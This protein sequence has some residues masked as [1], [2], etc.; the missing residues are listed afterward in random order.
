MKKIAFIL[1][2]TLAMATGVQAQW[3]ITT[4]IEGKVVN[5][6]DDNTFLGG[7]Y[8]GG[9][10]HFAFGKV[11]GLTLDGA[12]SKVTSTTSDYTLGVHTYYHNYSETL[13]HLPMMVDFRIPL[14]EESGIYVLCGPSLSFAITSAR[15]EWRDDD[16]PHTYINYYNGD[17]VSEDELLRRFNVSGTLG[18]C[19]RLRMFN[20][21][22]G[23]RMPLLNRRVADATK[24]TAVSLFLGVGLVF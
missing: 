18:A 5:S 17:E 3:H 23:A 6:G 9:G 7:L 10:Y 20:V 22:L 19:L 12:I 16:S 14:G 1:I 11:V 4:G 15:H 24:E 8:A 21:H 2:A 13:A